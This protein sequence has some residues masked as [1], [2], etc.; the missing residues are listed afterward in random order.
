MS[1]IWRFLV[2]LSLAFTGFVKSKRLYCESYGNK[3]AVVINGTEVCR[4]D[5]YFYCMVVWSTRFLED[6]TTVADV[7]SKGCFRIVFEQE[8]QKHPCNHNCVQQQHFDSMAK[9]KNISGFCCCDTDYCNKN[10]TIVEYKE[11]VVPTRTTGGKVH[12]TSNIN[13][14]VGIVLATLLL[15][16]I[17]VLFFWHYNNRKKHKY[18]RPDKSLEKEPQGPSL[19]LSQLTLGQ[20]IGQGR[21]G[22]VWKGTMFNEVMAVKVFGAEHR[23]FWQ[24]EKDLF[25][26]LDHHPSILRFF[27]ACE[28]ETNS[29]PEYLLLSEYH[30]RGSLQNYLRQHSVCWREMCIMGSSMSAGLAFLH[31]DANKPSFAHRD[32]NSKNI[33][34]K[35]DGSCVLAD[36]GFA[37]N[38]SDAT[39]PADDGTLI[40]EV[41][42]L[43]Y[44]APE[45]LDGAVNL[46]D[47]QGALKQI[48]VYAMSLVIWEVS[49]RCE[50][51]F[52]REQVPPYKAPFEAE[53]GPMITSEHMHT[54]VVQK[55][56]RPG[57]P[58]AWKRN[59]SGL[60]FLKETIEDCW[61]QDGDARLL[62][63][64]IKDR[65]SDLLTHYPNG[66][67]DS[68][69]SS[70]GTVQEFQENLKPEAQPEVSK[71]RMVVKI[72]ENQ[73]PGTVV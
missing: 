4:E 50:D 63:L 15:I 72:D 24:A 33:L 34:V 21:Y 46:H 23:L 16:T 56:L 35:V 71:N 32:I 2:L 3:D 5:P 26:A 11:K 38:V 69:Q 37:M 28:R 70:A 20:L 1:W 64:C 43:R 7:V 65:M 48:D 19:D 51:I 55:K 10:F 45:V 68:L 73:D 14:I 42:T 17:L 36:F 12:L 59:H 66:M 22:T 8:G 52:G 62:A 54:Y 30:P 25:S 13:I 9:S 57:F 27:A 47:I 40:T 49:M 18:S 31:Q 61:D 41:G 60:R 44:M 53:L 58:D 29:S 6:N 67:N 39:K